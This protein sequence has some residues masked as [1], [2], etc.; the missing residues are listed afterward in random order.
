MVNVGLPVA[1]RST[2]LVKEIEQVGKR[3]FIPVGHRGGMEKLGPVVGLVAFLVGGGCAAGAEPQDKVVSLG[4]DTRG[5]SSA[6]SVEEGRT[7]ER[8]GMTPDGLYRSADSGV[9]AASAGCAQE[10][11]R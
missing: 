8:L 5:A 1:G 4:T 11:A 6:A 9:L 10:L 7:R 2:A 3:I